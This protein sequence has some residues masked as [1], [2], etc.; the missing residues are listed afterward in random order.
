MKEPNIIQKIAFKVIG[1]SLNNLLTQ[2]LIPSYHYDF[3][4]GS[5]TFKMHNLDYLVKT[6]YQNNPI[7]FGIVNK[8]YLASKNLKFEQYIKGEPNGKSVD[9]DVSRLLKNLIL[10]GTAITNKRKLIGFP[11]EIEIIDTLN[12]E[13]QYYNGIFRYFEVKHG[14]RRELFHE[15]LTFTTIYLDPT[16][17]TNLGLSPLQASLMPIESLKEMYQ[18]D[19]SLL[20]NKGADLFI[21]NGSDTPLL[22]DE[23]GAFDNAM[24]ERIAGARNYGKAVTSTAKLDIKNIGR[25]TKEL[26]LWD[27]YKIKSRDICNALQVDSSL[28]ND[29]ESKKYSNVEEGQR[30]LYSECVIPFTK[31]ITEN[32]D[33]IN[34]LGHEVYV[35]T[36]EIECLQES[37]KARFEKNKIITDAIIELNAQIL[38]GVI[39]NKIAVNIMV[40]E[41]GFDKEEA[42]TYIK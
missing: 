16:K 23:Q 21:S 31:L 22:E 42:T 17:C 9:L 35:N 24:N 28:F 34:Q 20:K 3:I 18:A 40:T 10:T 7:V 27:G 37:Q 33:L 39:D 1:K 13:E 19:T 5:H 32:K 41:W 15:D 38:G 2:N 25:T 4:L 14:F 29:P 36:S 30:A 6:G 12:V 11:E 26:A 8:I